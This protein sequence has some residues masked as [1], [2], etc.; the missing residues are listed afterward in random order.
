MAQFKRILLTGA[1]GFVG[2][3]L[4]AALRAA[5]PEAHLIAAGARPPAPGLA[6]EALPLDLADPAG[7]E[8]CLAAARPD[9]VI[10]LAARTAVPDSFDDPALTWRV[11][12]DGSLALARA[13]LRHAPGALLV[14]ASSAEA[15]GLGFRTGQ[16]L[17]ET[18]AFAPANPYAASKAAA[19][20]AL[21]E[22]A[23]RGLRLCRLRPFN[24]TGPGQSA[25]FVVPAFARQLARIEAGLQPP[26]IRVGALDRWRDFLDV[27]DVVGA[28]LAALDHA[29]TL[30]AG[31]A[32]NV[33]A[34]ESR[35]IGDILE[36]LVHR[37]GRPVEVAAE[38][39][40]LRPLD[41]RAARCDAGAAARLLGWRPQVAWEATLDAVLEDWRMRVR[42]GS[43][44]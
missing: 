31:A 35:R 6:D 33:G 17:D 26:T 39:D 24:H 42:R 40:R 21:G 9:A 23:L 3:H 1:T 18:A 44:A 20:L 14:F 2:P 15:Y 7:I 4:L 13:M 22:M 11:N 36:A 29:A 34:G 19:D 27:R 43:D 28:Y 25:R 12:V 16:P 10:H 38:P 41:I 32:L 37:I 30:P 5:R 8:A